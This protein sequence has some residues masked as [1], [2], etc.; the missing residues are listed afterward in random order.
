MIVAALEIRQTR[1]DNLEPHC[2]NF[3]VLLTH[4]EFQEL[5]HQTLELALGFVTSSTSVEQPFHIT[6]DRLCVEV[7]LQDHEVQTMN[8]YRQEGCDCGAA[9]IELTWASKLQDLQTG[10]RSGKVLHIIV[11]QTKDTAP[12]DAVTVADAQRTQIP[13]LQD[14]R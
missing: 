14:G 5:H 8:R 3:N 1:K 12:L 11:R 2:D 4:F 10:E 7:S 13:E 9:E 6:D